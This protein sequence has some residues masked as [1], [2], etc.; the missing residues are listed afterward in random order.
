MQTKPGR[1]QTVVFIP[2]IEKI[3]EGA[4]LPDSPEK[5]MESA[6]HIPSIIG[7][8]DQEGLLMFIS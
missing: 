4:F 2:S 3:K 6:P 8:T 7:F 5:L 1:C